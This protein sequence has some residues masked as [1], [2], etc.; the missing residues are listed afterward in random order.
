LVS[1]QAFRYHEKVFSE[2]DTFGNIEYARAD[3][4]NNHIS[5]AGELQIHAGETQTENRG[6]FMDIFFMTI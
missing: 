3:W 6:L 2:I 1:A 5:L 4:L